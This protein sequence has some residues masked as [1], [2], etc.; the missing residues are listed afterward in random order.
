M[1]KKSNKIFSDKK[2]IITGD[3]EIEL[4]I[5]GSRPGEKLHE[6]LISGE[7]TVRTF[8]RENNFVIKPILPELRDDTVN[9][10]VLDGEFSSGDV[11]MPRAKVAE[12][13]KANGLL[14][15]DKV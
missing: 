14:L 3:R 2:I 11:V 13:L 9:G 7:E 8:K 1:A 12:L 10:N 5:I 4:N 15:D 6:V